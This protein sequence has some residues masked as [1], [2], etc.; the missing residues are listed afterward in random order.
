MSR[1]ERRDMEILRTLGRLRFLTTREISAT[2]FGG[3]DGARRRL[4]TLSD[5][6]LIRSHSKGMAPQMQYY[7]WRVTAAGIELVHELFPDEPLP[8]TLADRLAEA[9]LHDVLH[10][11]AVADVYLRYLVAGAP[12]PTSENAPALVRRRASIMRARAGHVFWQ[13]DGDVVLRLKTAAGERQVIPDATVCGRDRPVRVFLEVDRSS[14]PRSRLAKTLGHY[15]RFLREAYGT[16]F[17]DGRKAVVLYVVRS[18]QRRA[19]LAELA[20]RVFPADIAWDVVVVADAAAWLEERLVDRVKLARET[21]VQLARDEAA[22]PPSAS[23]VYAVA[24][25]IAHRLREAGQPLPAAA[26]VLA[27]RAL[28][29]TTLELLKAVEAYGEPV[30]DGA[31]SLLRRLH[32]ELTGGEPSAQVDDAA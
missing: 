31:V 12:P 14:W 1:L 23:R 17:T 16:V 8:E 11:E 29:N 13:A 6:D 26:A 22:P 21:S 27:P 10:R 19:S 5:M 3:V 4:R 7:A 15:R 25:E 24:A 2:F 32:R 30:P 20:G 18:E 9:T 28:Y